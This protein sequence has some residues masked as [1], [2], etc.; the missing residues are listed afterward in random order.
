MPGNV[1]NQILP[2][3]AHKIPGNIIDIIFNFILV[4]GPARQAYILVD[5][6]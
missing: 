1:I 3:N 5:G 4:L 2:G 6:R